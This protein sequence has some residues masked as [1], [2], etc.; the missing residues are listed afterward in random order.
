M[1][2]MSDEASGAAGEQNPASLTGTDFTVGIG[3]TVK[4]S[5]APVSNA[6]A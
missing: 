6:H 4:M 2:V 1:S 5:S 3:I